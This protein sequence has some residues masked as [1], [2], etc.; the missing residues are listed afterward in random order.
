MI[1][2]VALYVFLELAKNFKSGNIVMIT[3][4]RGG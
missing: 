3:P 4:G 2:A 1:E